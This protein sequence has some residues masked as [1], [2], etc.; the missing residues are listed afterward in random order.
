MTRIWCG[1][2]AELGFRGRD[3]G[4]NNVRDR[5]YNVEINNW[6]DKSRDSRSDCGKAAKSGADENTV[7]SRV[8]RRMSHFL[9]CASRYSGEGMGG[10][11]RSSNAEFN[12]VNVTATSR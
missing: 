11:K 4:V 5:A 6:G 10:G 1:R 12:K 7:V 8:M 2:N 3:E 9:R